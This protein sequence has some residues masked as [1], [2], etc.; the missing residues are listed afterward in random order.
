MMNEACKAEVEKALNWGHVTYVSMEPC[1][2]DFWTGGHKVVKPSVAA[3]QGIWEDYQ[4]WKSLNRR[5]VSVK[6]LEE[7]GELSAT[8]HSHRRSADLYLDISE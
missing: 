2:L 6:M 3:L 8:Y 5:N 1:Q 4:A 7:Q